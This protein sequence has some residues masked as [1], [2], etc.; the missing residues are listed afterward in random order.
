[1]FMRSIEVNSRCGELSFTVMTVCGSSTRQCSNAGL[2][3]G[4]RCRRWANI[5]SLSLVCFGIHGSPSNKG[6]FTN[7]DLMLA[8]AADDSHHWL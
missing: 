5:G 7:G 1:M 4:Q 3:L 2:L 6:P 8:D